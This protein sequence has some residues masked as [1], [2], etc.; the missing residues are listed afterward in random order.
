MY[1]RLP[2]CLLCIV[3]GEVFVQFDSANL[4]SA[5]LL[6]APQPPRIIQSYDVPLLIQVTN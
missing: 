6:R 1:V 4:L 3:I 2:A 5:R